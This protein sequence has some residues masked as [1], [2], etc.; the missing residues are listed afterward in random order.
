[1]FREIWE[2]LRGGPSDLLG[3][4]IQEK[5]LFAVRMRRRGR[6]L[7]VTAADSLPPAERTEAAYAYSSAAIPQRLKAKYAALAVPDESATVKLLTFPGRFDAA[8]ETKIVQDMGLENPDRYRVSYKLVSEGRG[9]AESRVVAAALPEEIARVYAMFIPAGRPAVFSVEVAPLARLT[10]FFHGPGR[11]QQAKCVGTLTF[12]DKTSCLAILNNGLPA[13]IRTFQIGTRQVLEKIEKSL[14]V[15]Q[16]TAEAVLAEGAIDI[17]QIVEEVLDPL[18]KQLTISRDFVERREGCHLERLFM[19][20]ALIAS[21]DVTDLIRST[22]GVA[23]ESWNPFDGLP[24]AAGAY[25]ETLKGQEWRFTAAIGA[26]LGVFEK[27]ES[28]H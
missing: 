19:G 25:P 9:R 17:S 26:C 16:S 1:S 4:E 13:L 10:A 12:G 20:G 2:R 28:T 21:H 27:N 15:D 11:H 24:I 7:L 6:E 23:V 3:L 18:L 14:G 22:I 8:A 5:A